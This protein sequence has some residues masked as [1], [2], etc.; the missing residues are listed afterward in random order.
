MRRDIDKLRSLSYPVEA[1]KGVTG[2]YRLGADASLPPLLLDDD[3]A[4]AVA[5]ALRS[6]AA[7]GGVTGVED[8]AVRALTKLEQVL[9]AALR[10]RVRTL[11]SVT[12]VMAGPG[13]TVD[14]DVLLAVAAATRDHQQLRV[15]YTGHDATTSRRILEPHQL[16]TS[17]RRWY[18]LAW[19]VD[20]HDWRTFRLDRLTPRTPTGP[21]F[22]PRDPP[23]S[24]LAAWTARGTT[25]RAYRYPGQFTVHAP[26]AA[27]ADR[28]PPEAGTIT[29][30]DDATCRL[31]CGSNSLDELAL[32]LGTLG[33]TVDVHHPTELLDHIRHLVDRFQPAAPQPSPC[34]T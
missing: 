15:D 1:R 13:S 27:V 26:A 11:A 5:I 32:W 14:T 25:S 31:D 16:V 30:I 6:A 22:V 2:G 8:G 33:A 29:P 23:D 4:V 28:I 9:P 19:D 21:R 12:A 20:R 17:G 10:Y 3:E 34:V 7:G 24:D 18:L